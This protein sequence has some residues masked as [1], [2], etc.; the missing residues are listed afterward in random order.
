[1]YKDLCEAAEHDSVLKGGQNK[2]MPHLMMRHLYKK[3][4]LMLFLVM[5]GV[6]LLYILI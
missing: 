2:K 6:A 5:P 3:Q 1:M 4:K